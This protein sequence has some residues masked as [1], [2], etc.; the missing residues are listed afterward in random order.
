MPQRRSFPLLAAFAGLLVAACGRDTSTLEPAPF[1]NAADI[2]TD[3]FGSGISFQG[4]AGSKSDA[5][6]IDSTVH[7]IGTA[8]LKVRIPALGDASGG[9]SGGAFVAGIPRDL[10]GYNAV[11]FWAKASISASLDVAGLGNDNT[12][13]SKYTAQRSAIQLTTAWRKYVI[14]I[15]L[16]SKLPAERGMFFFA[17]G[18]ENGAG[19]ELWLDDIKYESLATITNPRGA[20]PT[21]TIIGE[22]GAVVPVTGTTVTVAV[23]GADVTVNASPNYFTFASSNQSVAT[24]APNGSITTV[25]VGT[26]S[27]TAAL[28]STNASGTVTL[29]TLAPPATPA[30]VPTRPAA[31]VISLFSDSY[32]NRT[33]DTWSASYDQ[34]DVA[35]VQIA[36]NAVKK[37]TNVSYAAI[38]F[39]SRPVDATAMTALHLDVYVF[40]SSAFKVKLVDF[41]AN[42]VF[43]GGDDTEHE[44][45]LSATTTPKVTAGAWS[46]LDIPLSA[47]SGLRSTAHLAQLIVSG[48]SP[49]VYLDNLY[50]YRTAAPPPPDA[51]TTAAPTPTAAPANVISLF[52]NAY[53]NVPVTTWSADWDQAD[54]ADVKVA[55]DDVKKY[56]N[57]VFAGIEFTAPT[58]DASAMTTFHIDVWTPSPTTTAA[59][60][61]KLVDF[62]AN[63]VFGGGDDVEQELTFTRTSTPALTTGSWISFEI[64]LSAFTGLTTRAHLAQL[65]VSGDLPTIYVDNVYFARSG[66]TATA[67]STAAPTPTFA[68]ANVISLF[69]N[70][71][72]NVPVTTWSADW[73][74]ADVADVKVAG[75]DVKKYTNLVFAGIEFTAPTIDAS[76]MTTFH[77]DVWTPSPTTTAAF[78][79]KLVDFGANGV[80]GGGDDVEQ[81]LTFTRTSTPALTTGSWISF[82]IPLSAFTGLTTRAHLAQLIVSGDLP[83]IYADNV[84]FHK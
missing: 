18:P 71:Y 52:S 44:V 11:T 6:S 10:S 83:T 25:G 9:Y 67:P 63:G 21:R 24:I 73:D 4:F 61:I 1:P 42:G 50:F 28:G 27:I 58:I 69:S 22:V 82:E 8:S 15:P 34:A 76:A 13:T 62:G 79:I 48:S 77:I 17:E 20:M 74:Q 78:R 37:Y 81:E 36:G 40:D 41:G 57:L 31:D 56:T 26:A 32:P 30:P 65:I 39:T 64:P 35:D 47:F 54:V 53:T 19:Y 12:G 7:R 3:G 23:D 5:L 60:R 45:T 66:G 43:G 80:F 68:A 59:F 75:D 72:T 38:E 16:A 33:V 29:R 49:T 14:P 84:L 55:G 2:F 46:S 51:P 70:G